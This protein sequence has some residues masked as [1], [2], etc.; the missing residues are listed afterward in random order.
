MKVGELIKYL[1][2]FDA[3]LRVMFN[4]PD[5]YLEEVGSAEVEQV[6][7]SGNS[8]HMFGRYQAYYTGKTLKPEFSEPFNVLVLYYED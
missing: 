3:D 5:I 1:E 2:G 7:N 8:G 6:V 4:I